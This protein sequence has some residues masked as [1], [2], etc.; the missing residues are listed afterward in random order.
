[1]SKPVVFLVPCLFYPEN[2]TFDDHLKQAEQ[3]LKS[4]KERVSNCTR[5]FIVF[6]TLTIEQKFRL[7]Q[8]FEYF[9][10]LTGNN[11]ATM[12]AKQ[13]SIGDIILL[14]FAVNQLLQMGSEFRSLFVLNSRY[15]L[16]ASFKVQEFPVNK[17]TFRQEVNET[18][19]YFLTSLY[20]I[21]DK[22]NLWNFQNLLFHSLVRLFSGEI[23]SEHS[24]RAILPDNT[25][26]LKSELGISTAGQPIRH[27]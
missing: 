3:S 13:K 11:V 7:S 25:L 21:G 20:C 2:G 10:D 17:F 23:D 9:F 8:H 18:G 27:V 1:M 6:Q 24:F 5:I 15:L 19:R 22:G 26:Y 4:I 12:L 14:Y 16:N